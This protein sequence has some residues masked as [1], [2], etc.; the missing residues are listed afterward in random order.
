MGETG[1]ARPK[2]RG[3]YKPGPGRPKGRK[4]NATLALEAAAQEAA[5]SIDEAFEGDAHAFLVAVYRNPA[6]PLELRI[7]AASR[8]LKVE[9]PALSAAREQID[10]S[11]NIGA[12][13]EAAQRRIAGSAV[14]VIE[15]EAVGVRCHGG[16]SQC[17]T[18][19]G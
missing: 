12:R 18:P 3:N 6:V 16:V 17:Q 5:A 7:M 10:V 11:V 4:N 15:G 13:L 19:R 8:A 14:R 9:K 1:E 2:R